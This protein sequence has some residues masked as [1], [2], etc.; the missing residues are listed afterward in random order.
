MTK[1]PNPPFIIGLTGG[2]GSGKTT[3]S[4]YFAKL[5]IDV[6]DAD[7]ISHTITAKGSP[8]LDKLALAFG[9]DIITDGR[10]DRTYLRKIAFANDA[11]LTTLNA[12]I[13]PNQA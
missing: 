10:L 8:V 11:K 4:D 13:H 6:I 5:G 1:S 9:T 7:V 2:I 12:I 3:V